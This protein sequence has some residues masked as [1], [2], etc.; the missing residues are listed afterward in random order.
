MMAV[1]LALVVIVEVPEVVW[2]VSTFAATPLL[3]N[4]QGPGVEGSVSPKSRFPMVRAVSRITLVVPETSSVLKSAVA[5]IPSATVVPAQF[6]GTL[7]VPLAA[8]VPLVATHVPLSARA[9]CCGRNSAAAKTVTMKNEQRSHRRNGRRMDNRFIT[10]I[11]L[12]W[13]WVGN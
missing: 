10:R 9:D 5:S 4:N 8:T 13:I 7:Q 11:G 12:G 3:V 6:A 2:S 1:V